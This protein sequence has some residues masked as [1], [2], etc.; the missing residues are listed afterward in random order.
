MSLATETPAPPTSDEGLLPACISLSLIKP[1]HVES[2]VLTKT[3]DEDILEYLGYNAISISIDS[4][5]ES[6]CHLKQDD[7]RGELAELIK[8]ECNARKILLRVG[9]M[10]CFLKF[11]VHDES[12]KEII[13][14]FSTCPSDMRACIVSIGCEGSRRDFHNR[15][16]LPAMENKKETL[17]LHSFRHYLT[18]FTSKNTF[19]GVGAMRYDHDARTEIKILKSLLPFLLLM[20]GEVVYDLL[21]GVTKEGSGEAFRILHKA[22]IA[23]DPFH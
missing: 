19:P 7:S 18:S 13:L 16:I 12:K 15:S 9:Q 11:V 14:F 4:L 23:R 8:E 3:S 6:V 5:L 22:K 10:I 20:E 1:E 2:M 17:R 21:C